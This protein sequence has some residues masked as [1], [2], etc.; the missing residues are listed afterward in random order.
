MMQLYTYEFCRMTKLH[1]D[2]TL[3]T[4][5]LDVTLIIETMHQTIE[6]E[7]ELHKQFDSANQKI[8]NQV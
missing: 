6:F 1:L 5:Q 4:Q 2:E 3:S 8:K 7:N